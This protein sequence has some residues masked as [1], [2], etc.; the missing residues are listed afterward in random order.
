MIKKIFIIFINI[1]I[2][3]CIFIIFD[4]LVFRQEV[5]LY[6]KSCTISNMLTSYKNFVFRDISPESIKKRIINGENLGYHQPKNIDSTENSIILFGCSFVYGHKIPE[7]KTLHS[8]LANYTTRPIYDRSFHGW[9]INQMLYQLKSDEFY[10]LFPQKPKYI[11]F[12]YFNGHITRLYSPIFPTIVE[13]HGTYYN[14]D[15]K[16]N[17]LRLKK[18]S[19]LFERF[20]S[21]EKIRYLI[22]NIFLTDNKRSEFLLK[23]FIDA[24]ESVDLHWPG[25]K[26]IILSKRL[27]FKLKFILFTSVDLII[28]PD[29]VKYLLF[30]FIFLKDAVPLSSI[31]NLY[32]SIISPL[33]NNIISQT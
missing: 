5:K 20:I 7:E 11:I 22:Y 14:I 3:V 32:L 1:L 16:T 17:K 33:I 15:K 27:I 24:K 26:F 19:Q 2:I 21:L 25:V 13:Y 6:F 9:G 4:F 31:Y 29:N 23:H 30:P 10:K 18:P 8:V 28:I 12:N